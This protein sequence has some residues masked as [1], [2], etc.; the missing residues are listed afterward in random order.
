LANK[1][2]S[3]DFNSEEEDSLLSMQDLM[4]VDEGNETSSEAM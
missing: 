3:T 2:G 4:G 1:G